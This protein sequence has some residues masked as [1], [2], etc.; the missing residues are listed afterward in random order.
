VSL[1]YLSTLRFDADWLAGLHAFVP[2]LEVRQI[3]TDDPADIPADL[4]RRVEVLHTSAALPEPEWAPSLKLVQLDTSGVEH[5]AG[6]A[7]WRSAVPIAN[8]AGIAGVPM[9][10]YVLMC[11]LA[12]A[13]RVPALRAARTAHDWPEHAER[14][15]RFT[16][17]PLP[18][19]TLVIVGYGRIGAEVA[20]LA[21]AHGVHV[22]GVRRRIDGAPAAATAEPVRV[23]ALD[24]LHEVLALA[25]HVVVLLPST[26][27]TRGCF[28]AAAVAAMRPGATLVNASRGGIVDTAALLAAVHSGRLAGAALDVFDVEPLPVDDPLWDDPQI[29]LTPHIAGLAPAYAAGVAELV[30]ENLRRLAAGRPLVNLVDRASGY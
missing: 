16:P 12:L 28:D 15:R 3:T 5:V 6:T 19:S 8:I 27:V 14:L 17:L 24:R 29:L 22:I 11:V 20:R 25:D 10:E 18:G 1:T 26:D 13:H 23:V 4:W 21:G 9:A 2:D 30:G 7:L